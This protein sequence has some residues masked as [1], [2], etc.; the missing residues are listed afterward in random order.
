MLIKDKETLVV[1][2]MG[3]EFHSKKTQPVSEHLLT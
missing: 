1:K 2:K 3:S